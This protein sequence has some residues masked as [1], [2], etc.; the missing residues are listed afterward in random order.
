T[1]VRPRTSAPDGANG[2]TSQRTSTP[3]RKRTSHRTSAPAV[4]AQRPDIT[5][6]E[7]ARLTGITDRH[8]RRL[9]NGNRNADAKAGNGVRPDVQPSAERDA[10]VDITVG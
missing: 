3:P 1:S 2:R 9:V 4:L 5:A 8:A 7:L 10:V 6:A